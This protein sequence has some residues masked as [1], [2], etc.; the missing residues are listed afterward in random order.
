VI[1]YA[2][3]AAWIWSDQGFLNQLGAIDNAGCGVGTRQWASNK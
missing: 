3:P 1:V 2:L